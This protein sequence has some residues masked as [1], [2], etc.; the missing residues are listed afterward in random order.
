MR[1]EA[2]DGGGINNAN[3][4]TPPVDGSPARMQ[5]YLWPGN[6]FGAQNQVVVDGVG[7]F[8]AG[9]ARFGPAPTVTGLAGQ[10]VV[11]AGTGCDAGSYPAPL[12]SS[13]WVVVVDGGTRACGYRQRVEVAQ[14]LGANAMILAHT[15]S[16]PPILS[17]PLSGRP[18]EIPAVAVSWADGQ[19]IKAA[20]AEGPRTASVRKHPDHPGIRD[21]DLETRSSSTSTPTGCRT[22]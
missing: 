19:A 6:Q 10:T 16:A 1:A 17:A 5:M 21:G 18:L 14:E 2:A 9:W 20:V 22:G 13:P 7:E 8:D 11:Y 12:P 15:G 4:A 3:F